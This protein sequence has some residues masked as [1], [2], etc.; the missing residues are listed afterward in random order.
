[1]RI[2]R[3]RVS[4]VWCA[5]NARVVGTGP[6][7]FLGLES[8]SL[9]ASI[10]L[11]PRHLSGTADLSIANPPATTLLAVAHPCRAALR[12]M[13]TRR[14]LLRVLD[15]LPRRLTT[16]EQ[17]RDDEL[18]S[19]SCAPPHAAVAALRGAAPRSA[20]SGGRDAV[21]GRRL[22]SFELG[23]AAV[24]TAG[25]GQDVPP[26]RARS[27]SSLRLKVSS[28]AHAAAPTAGREPPPPPPPRARA[29]RLVAPRRRLTRRPP[30]SRWPARSA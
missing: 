24:P 20:A 3:A 5:A 8:A 16:D 15:V 14:A 22:G 2:L 18:R 9:E 17:R 21:A 26:R 13:S 27:A 11:R 7:C 30:R 23:C 28:P 10:A 4:L 19:A 6:R 1:M 29:R 12:P 25:R